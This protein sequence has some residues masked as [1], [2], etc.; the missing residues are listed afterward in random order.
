MGL[1]WGPP[2]AARSGPV[3]GTSKAPLGY[4]AVVVIRATNARYN[5][6]FERVKGENSRWKLASTRGEQEDADEL[7]AI[8]G[9]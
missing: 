2:K 8:V 3:F 6:I 5:C 7:Q 1:V 4:T 9:M